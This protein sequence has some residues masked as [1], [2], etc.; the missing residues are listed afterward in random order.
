MRRSR[1]VM[2]QD[3]Y[4]I[5]LREVLEANTYFCMNFVLF[6]PV[7]S[8][9]FLFLFLPGFEHTH[10][11]MCFVFIYCIRYTNWIKNTLYFVLRKWKRSIFNWPIQFK[12]IGFESRIAESRKLN[13]KKVYKLFALHWGNYHSIESVETAIDQMRHKRFCSLLKGCSLSCH[14]CGT[15][16]ITLGKE[17][18]PNKNWI[19]HEMNKI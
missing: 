3:Y 18:N 12:V 16:C 10:H 1:W 13:K 9:F 7:N 14:H 19:K 2:S 11:F 15:P 6:F 5:I 8:I 4:F 17:W